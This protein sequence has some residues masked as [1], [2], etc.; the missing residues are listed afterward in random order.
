MPDL[1]FEEEHE[2]PVVVF[3]YDRD[4]AAGEEDRPSDN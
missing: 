1:P 2:L 4:E 3:I